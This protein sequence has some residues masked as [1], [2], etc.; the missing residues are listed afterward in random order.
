[1]RFLRVP[2]QL[3]ERWLHFGRQHQEEFHGLD[4]EDYIRR[5]IG[6]LN[7][8]AP[9]VQPDGDISHQGKLQWTYGRA[10]HWCSRPAVTITRVIRNRHH[11]RRH[12]QSTDRLPQRST[13]RG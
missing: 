4:G 3:T 7:E 8:T 1:M 12:R 13:S 9:E 5:N 11:R 2:G 10:R 6:A